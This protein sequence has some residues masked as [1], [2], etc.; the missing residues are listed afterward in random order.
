MIVE[1]EGKVE[2][3]SD[4]VTNKAGLYPKRNLVIFQENGDYPDYIT[5]EVQERSFDLFADIKVNSEVKVITNFGGRM[6][7]NPEGVKIGF[8][9]CKAWKYEELSAAQSEF[10]AADVPPAPEDDGSDLPF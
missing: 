1:I 6:W 9:S 5:I 2:S 7:T 8:N 10:S 4:I 3:Y